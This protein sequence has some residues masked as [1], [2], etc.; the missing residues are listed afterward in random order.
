LADADGKDPDFTKSQIFG[1]NQARE[2]FKALF[3]EIKYWHLSNSAGT[4]F[5]G[6]IN[7]NVVRLGIAL[8][9]FD[10][11]GK[12]PDLKPCLAMKTLVTGV[13][14]IQP[15]DFVG[16]NI[17][18]RADSKMVVAT[19]P[20]GYFEGVDRR[21]S[22]IGFVKIKG[23]F[24]KILGRVSMNLTVVDVTSVPDLKVGEEAVVISGEIEDKNSAIAAAKECNTI[25]YDILVRIPQHLRREVVNG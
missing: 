22:N 21:L 7:A 24:C 8:Y 9:G 10:Q 15:G 19:L 11:S 12:M 1:W 13:K 20:V 17:T 3:P 25:V 23:Q 4:A 5:A 18:F 2:K 16:Y 14:S 6:Q